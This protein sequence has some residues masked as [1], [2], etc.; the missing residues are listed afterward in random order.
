MKCDFC[1][2]EFINKYTMQKHQQ[3]TKYCIDIQKK[4]NIETK[5]D[6][7]QCEYCQKKFEYDIW[8]VENISFLLDLKIVLLTIKKVFKREGIYQEGQFSN[9]PFNG[10]N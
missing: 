9:E 2:N 3:R 8:Y 6:F 4:L 10:N 5:E 7:K 1:K